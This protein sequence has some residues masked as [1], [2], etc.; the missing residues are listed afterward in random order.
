[1]VVLSDIDDDTDDETSK[2]KKVKI[3]ECD[4]VLFNA[5]QAVSSQLKC[6]RKFDASSSSHC[7]EVLCPPPNFI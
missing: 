4:F 2:D 1:M 6:T 3:F 7:R 5:N